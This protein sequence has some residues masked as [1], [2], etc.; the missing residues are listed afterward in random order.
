[1][2][3]ICHFS[4]KRKAVSLCDTTMKENIQIHQHREIKGNLLDAYLAN[5]WYRYGSHIFTIDTFS[6][7]DQTYHVHW[8]RYRVPDI[9]LNKK[10]QQL[11]KK[12][13]GFQIMVKPF[14]LTEELERLHDLYFLNIS[15]TTSV[16]LK[17]LLEDE[18]GKVFDTYLAEIRD[19]EK[20][21]AAGIF[22]GGKQ[23]I[24]GIKNILHPDYKKYSLGKM[25]MLIK[26][27]FCVRT[28]LQ[29]YYPGYIAP[30]Y[31]RFDYKL[32]M[33][34]GAT[35]VYDPSASRWVP[36]GSFFSSDNIT[37]P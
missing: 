36:Y 14:E 13:S 9:S 16:T 8:I 17:D 11:I 22:D 5:G 1:V 2:D 19:G 23:S 10:Q 20:L 21:I 7:N 4:I 28:G 30:G 26:Y 33:D 24:A 25:L 31:P 29:Y 37:S 18:E 35:E 32:F 27:R 34:N 3:D 6:E 15:F 12:C